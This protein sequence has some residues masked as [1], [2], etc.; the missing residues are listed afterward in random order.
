M[1]KTNNLTD[2][3]TD[4]A[5]AIRE[6]EGSTEAI[7]P[8]A[9]SQRILALQTGGG[10]GASASAG[11]VNFRD[12]DGTIL[13]SFSKDEFLALTEFPALPTQKGLTCQGWNY[14][15]DDAKAYVQEYGVLEIGATYITDDGK[16]RLYITIAEGRMDVPLMLKQKASY[17]V[18]VDWGDGSTET[19]SGTSATT[20]RHTYGKA[21]DYVI[22]LEVIN[23]TLSLSG[24]TSGGIFAD[25]MKVYGNILKKVEIGNNVTIGGYTF[26]GCHSLAS[27]VIPNSVT[28]IGTEV[29]Y[30]CYSLASVVIPNSVTSIGS[31]IFNTCYSLAS[32]VIPNSVT[33]IG[34]SAFFTCYSL[35][36]VVIP[37]SVT[38]IGSNAFYTCYS[39]ASVVIP[40]SVTSIGS[41]AFYNCYSLA[42]VVIPNS[43][44]SIRTKAFRSCY[45]L[46][47]VVIP[48]SVTSIE[49]ETFYYCRS[50]ASVVIPNSVTSIGGSAFY[51]CY[52]L[53]SVV[54]PNSVT[55]I[56][57]NA[58][59]NC[60]SVAFY[61]FRTHTSVP[62]LSNTNAFSSIV[63]DCKIVVSDALYDAWIAAS[64]WSTYA[65]YI[66]KASEFN[67]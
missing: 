40:N 33:S 22:A 1:A 51:T 10:G 17:G 63:S 42:S 31:N 23:S 61:D 8:Q 64:N 48:N 36:S 54:I 35:A 9:F 39:L 7:N 50:L 29:F 13:H 56:G 6:K 65:S 32:V 4:V 41:N 44:T 49:T 62:T 46:A 24:S 52:S 43:V 18:V 2:F 12:Y 21:G 3:L 53:A 5:D 14:N 47:S 34:D 19:F 26:S 30:N 60:S 57:S 66:V 11:A 55:S 38:S 45:S 27:V 58:F 25:S 28:S 15:I 59:Y 16:T 37:N 67:G 20:L